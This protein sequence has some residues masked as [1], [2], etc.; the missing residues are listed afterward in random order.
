M[1]FNLYESKTD[2]DF[3][4]ASVQEKLILSEKIVKNE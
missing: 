1:N 4:Y 2:N 3:T